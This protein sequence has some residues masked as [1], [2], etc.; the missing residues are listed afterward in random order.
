MPA[1]TL[2]RVLFP[3]PLRPTMPKL[4]PACTE[5]DTSSKRPQRLGRE[6]LATEAADRV[7]AD[8]DHPLLLEVVTYRQAVDGDACDRRVILGS[9]R[10][11]M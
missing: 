7:L 11:Q 3:A 10:A 2:R 5:K 4:S 1:I 9:R 8:R 6:A